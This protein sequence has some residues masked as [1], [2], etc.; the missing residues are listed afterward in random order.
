MN[1]YVCSCC[2]VGEPVLVLHVLT[3]E[4]SRGDYAAAHGV[5]VL[6][7]VCSDACKRKLTR[8]FE[9][10]GCHVLR[11]SLVEYLDVRGQK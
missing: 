5:W 6:R 10:R 2:F 11:W 8:H 3:P 9:R 4:G 7:T 1:R